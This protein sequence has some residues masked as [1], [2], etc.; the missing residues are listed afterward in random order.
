MRLI[1]KQRVTWLIVCL[2]ACVVPI[3]AGACGSREDG[4]PVGGTVVIGLLGDPETLNPLVATTVESKD[5]INLVYMRLLDE[6]ADFISFKPKLAKSWEFSRDSL[7]ITFSLR[8]DVLWEDGVP[9]TA[10]DVRYTWELQTDTTVA[11]ASRHLKDRIED[12][13]VVDDF[14]VVFHFTNRYLYQLMDANDGVILPKHVVE[15]IPRAEF[16]TSKFGRDPVGNGP[17][18][19]ARWVSGQYVE[20]ERNPNYF[21]GERPYLDGVVY[22]IVP[23]MTTLVTQLKTGEIDCLESVPND[24]LP[25][26]RRDNPDIKIYSY[27]SR[28]YTFVV[29]NLKKP[30]F[31][32]AEVRRALAMAVD[33]Q[34]M[35]ETLWGGMAQPMNSPMHPI[36]WAH[37]PTIKRIEFDPGRAKKILAAQG[38]VDRDGDGFIEKDGEP[39]EFEMTTN[40]G[41]QLRA[42]IATMCQEYFRHVGIRAT[43]RMMEWNTFI[44]WVIAG[45]F[46]SCVLGWGVGTRADLTNL[47]KS[48]SRPPGGLNV[49]GFASPAV[50]SLIDR[51][52][53]KLGP[54]EAQPLWYRC[55]RIIYDDQPFLFLTVPHEV[56]GLNRR[57]Q[58]VEPNAIGFFVN[59]PDWYVG[60]RE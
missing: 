27:P 41:N 12:V 18:R 26:V 36:L 48:T 29:W 34:E 30:L 54:T 58:G 11:W 40:Q 14:T 49:S 45:E 4:K 55:Q 25:G 51:A 56:V 16:R 21:E 47:W 59:L 3:L 33:V 5:I 19:L 42:D 13:E 2:L 46:D 38:W 50:D 28:D 39:F 57:I 15:K 9:F 52:K 10:A 44:Q 35:I 37:D 24:A 60:E 6:Q 31:E 7:S 43:I 20:L 53:N 22:R 8:E 32:N 23:D 1:P 17:F